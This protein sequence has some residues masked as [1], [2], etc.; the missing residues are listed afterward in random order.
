LGPAHKGKRQIVLFQPFGN[1][2][3]FP[4]FDSRANL[5]PHTGQTDVGFLSS[6]RIVAYP[7]ITPVF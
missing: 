4:S 2:Y 7:D 1:A 5:Q 6:G 3:H